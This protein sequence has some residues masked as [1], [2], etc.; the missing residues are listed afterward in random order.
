MAKVS[1][2]FSVYMCDLMKEC[3]VTYNDIASEVGESYNWVWRGVHSNSPDVIQFLK[4]CTYF[5]NQVKVPVEYII[6][7]ASASLGVNIYVHLEKR[8]YMVNRPENKDVKYVLHNEAVRNENE[9]KKN[10]E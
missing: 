5:A 10:G 3:N 6:E 2:G 8:V 7:R 4:L 9:N 1:N